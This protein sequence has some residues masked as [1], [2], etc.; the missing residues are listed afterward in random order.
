MQYRLVKIPGMPIVGVESRYVLQVREGIT[1]DATWT[2]VPIVL[3]Q[4]LTESE[5]HELAQVLHPR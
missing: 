4:D 5:R 1:H 2:T 3:F